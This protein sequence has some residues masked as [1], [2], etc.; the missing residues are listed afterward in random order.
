MGTKSQFLVELVQ[1]YSFESL[2][3]LV[4]GYL[5]FSV[6]MRKRMVIILVQDFYVQC[7]NKTG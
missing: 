2:P 5:T 6:D 1:V 3:M 7:N 4:G